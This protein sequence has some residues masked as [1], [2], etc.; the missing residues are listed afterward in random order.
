M[1]EWNTGIK[2]A[3]LQPAEKS[4]SLMEQDWK[5]T[6]SHLA[7]PSLLRSPLG[8][9]GWGKGRKAIHRFTQWWIR[10]GEPI[11]KYAQTHALAV[12]NMHTYGLAVLCLCLRICWAENDSR[13]RRW[14]Q[15]TQRRTTTW[16][17]Y[18]PHHATCS[19]QRKMSTLR[20]KDSVALLRLLLFHA[21]P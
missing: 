11:P 7:F 10:A 1:G 4:P 6:I 17:P 3:S 13:A 19:P 15:R 8:F 14:T 12:S 2:A 18:C 9:K 20:P 16:H 5:D 21:V